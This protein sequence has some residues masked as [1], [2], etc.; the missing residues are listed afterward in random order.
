[1]E[2]S[3]HTLKSLLKIGSEA[4]SGMMQAYIALDELDKADGRGNIGADR[5]RGAAKYFDWCAER[6]RLLAD[7]IEK[8]QNNV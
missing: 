8:E 2:L 5:L 4:H 3:S 6:L 7:R 1:M